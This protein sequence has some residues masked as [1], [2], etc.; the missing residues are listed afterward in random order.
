MTIWDTIKRCGEVIGAVVVLYGFVAGI[1]VAC[2]GALPPWYS[3]A[4]AQTLEDSLKTF[5]ADQQRSDRAR[6]ANIDLMFLSQLRAEAEKAD[7]KVA[8]HPKDQ[9][10]KADAWFARKKLDIFFRAHSNLAAQLQ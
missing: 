6:D 1:I 8:A 4:Q 2:G 5:E 3:I 7:A 9:A 10:A